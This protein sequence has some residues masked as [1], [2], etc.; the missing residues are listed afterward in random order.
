M[1]IINYEK[2]SI[3]KVEIKEKEKILSAK[4]IKSPFIY[5]KI[6]LNLNEK[7]RLNII[8]YNKQYQK[9]FGINIQDYKNLCLRI[10][11]GERNGKGE[12]YNKEGKLVFKGE[13]LKGKRNGKGEEYNREG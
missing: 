12:E 7:K 4:N 9:L 8:M 1:G 10:V 2:E 13:Y 6:L 3:A 5:K 11:K